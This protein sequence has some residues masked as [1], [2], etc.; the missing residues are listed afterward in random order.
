MDIGTTVIPLYSPEERIIKDEN[1]YNT[2]GVNNP[3]VDVYEK[4]TGQPYLNKREFAHAHPV[5]L[6]GYVNKKLGKNDYYFSLRG[7]DD[8]TVKVNRQKHTLRLNGYNL[9]EE[10]KV[11]ISAPKGLQTE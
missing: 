8:E 4:E 7:G 2:E 3:L 5:I 1:D 9:G 10:T 6:K 11:M